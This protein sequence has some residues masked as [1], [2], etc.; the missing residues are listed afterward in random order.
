M[1]NQIPPGTWPEHVRFDV[2]TEGPDSVR[3]FV[4][5]TGLTLA[6]RGDVSLRARGRFGPEGAFADLLV[7]SGLD[8]PRDSLVDPRSQMR[9]RLDRAFGTTSNTGPGA[10][11]GEASLP[12]DVLMRGTGFA[13]VRLRL[14]PFAV[15]VD[16][17]DVGLDLQIHDVPVPT[18]RSGRYLL[19]NGSL[20]A[21]G[22]A[23][24]PRARFRG[25]FVFQD[26]K[27]LQ[28]YR[29][30]L[31]ADVGPD[32]GVVA[33]ARLLDRDREIITARADLPADVSLRPLSFRPRPDTEA[34]A[35]LDAPSVDLSRFAALLPPKYSIAGKLE[36]HVEAD[37][38]ADDPRLSGSVRARDLQANLADGSRVIAGAKIDLGGTATR[39]GVH[40]RVDVENGVLVVPEQSREILP[41]QGDALLWTSATRQAD[42]SGT[43]GPPDLR[44]KPKKIE[45]DLNVKI[46]IPG[47]FWIRGEGLDVELGGELVVQTEQLLIISG[48]LKALRG[49]YRLLGRVF[50]VEQGTVQFYGEDE[51]NPVLD[52]SLTTRV[53]GIL[54][55]VSLYGTVRE[56]ELVLS[57]E[58]PMAD[59][60]ILSYLVL[61]RSMEDLDQNQVGLLKTRATDIAAVFGTS[62]IQSELEKRLGFDL[63]SIRQSSGPDQGSALVL[64]KYLS[65]RILLKYEQ[66]LDTGSS[67]FF[68]LEYLL[69]RSLRLETLAG[70]QQSGVEVNW[71]RDY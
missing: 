20:A 3:A 21:R 19:A 51:L 38:P 50:E 28:D 13:P 14:M 8:A 10:A 15:S 42:E 62:Q 34:S 24:S 7:G 2:Q 60:D 31:E 29:A 22:R 35:R 61:G 67:F 12:E 25:S 69:T 66:G 1:P 59:G 36:A 30:E 65:P 26:W 9:D 48:D 47:G 68:N 46:S 70:E 52:L 41:V 37:G 57:S 11:N 55:R 71:T 40:G 49:E 53:E 18:T 4:E 54:F 16:S 17:G 23:A 45:P 56:P 27:E 44:Q 64:G 33:S 43:M 5:A 6:D 58:P 32:S 63:V 39:P